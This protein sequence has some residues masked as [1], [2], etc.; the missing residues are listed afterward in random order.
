MLRKSISIKKAKILIM[1]FSFKENCS[2]IRN[3][4]VINV[5]DEL[6]EF[7]CKIEVYDPLVIPEDAL[8]LYQINISN[9]IPIEKYSGVFIAVP[10]KCFLDLGIEG[11]TKYCEKNHVI[12]DFKYLFP[13]D[14][15]IE[16]I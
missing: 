8:K 10:H 14:E 15:R 12:F 16:R 5:V 3:S 9:D 4:G 2:D 6:K 13:M 7:G 1:G 11:I